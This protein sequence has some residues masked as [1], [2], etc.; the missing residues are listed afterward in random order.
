MPLHTLNKKLRRPVGIVLCTCFLFMANASSATEES[1]ETVLPSM[2][3]FA[4]KQPD[5]TFTQTSEVAWDIKN[6]PTI[7]L[8]A[9]GEYTAKSTTNSYSL[10]SL[11]VS[12]GRP[13]INIDIGYALNSVSM[14][15]GGRSTLATLIES[16]RYLESG[17]T[18]K[19]T[20]ADALEAASKGVIQRRVDALREVLDRETH[21]KVNVISG[22]GLLDVA[23]TTKHSDVWRIQIRRE[24]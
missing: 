19:L 14:T 8:E 2:T 1:S 6:D 7:T 3:V 20:Y 15:A 9:D 24:S 4:T 10:K 13:T 12:L 5:N 17:A 18:L 23:P 11:I 16:L 21:V 22:K